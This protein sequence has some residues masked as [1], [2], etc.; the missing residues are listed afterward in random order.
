MAAGPWRFYVYELTDESGRVAYVGK[1]SGSRLASQRRNHALDGREVARFRR[2]KDAYAFEIDRIAESKPLRNKC[3]GG[4]GSWSTPAPK[5]RRTQWELEMERVGIRVYVARFLLEKRRAVNY[6]RAHQYFEPSVLA[7]IDGLD[8][9][10]L[11][12]VASSTVETN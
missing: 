4:N 8:V 3:K 12:A 5:R 6:L 10:A 2:E 9:S 1:G 7:A 11:R